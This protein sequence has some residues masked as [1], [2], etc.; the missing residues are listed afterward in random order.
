MTDH[1]KYYYESG[2]NGWTPTTSW[3]DEVVKDKDGK[4]DGGNINPKMLLNKKEIKL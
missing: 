1:N 4:W 3:Q 2:R